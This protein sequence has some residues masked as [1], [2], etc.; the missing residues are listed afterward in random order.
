MA[1]EYRVPLMLPSLVLIPAGLCWYGWSVEAYTHWAVVDVRIGV[2]GCGIIIGIV[3]LQ[4]YVMD[5]F[6]DH[7][8]LPTLRH[9]FSAL[10]LRLCFSSLC[11][12]CMTLWVMA[13]GTLSW[14]CTL[15]IRGETQG[16]EE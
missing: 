16:E 7:V 2:F 12:Q 9:N 1:P 4:A 5:A 13:K 10:C 8:A 11:R 14:R 15:E 6:P 3:M